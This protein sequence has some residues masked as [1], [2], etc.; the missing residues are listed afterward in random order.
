MKDALPFLSP[1]KQWTNGALLSAPYRSMAHACRDGSNHECGNHGLNLPNMTARSALATRLV[2]VG[3]ALG[4][5]V[6]AEGRALE[7]L[8][9]RR[10]AAALLHPAKHAV[11]GVRSATL[12]GIIVRVA[13]GHELVHQCR[14]EA[15]EHSLCGEDVVERA[16]DEV[17]AFGSVRFPV[18]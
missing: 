3:Q 5:A 12:A 2:Q 4:R 11:L 18:K 16:V 10:L 1:S 7:A 8:G 14:R 9:R 6:L 15:A 13:E 17:L